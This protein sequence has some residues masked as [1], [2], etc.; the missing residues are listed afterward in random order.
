M[1]MAI[2]WEMIPPN[3]SI[4]DFVLLT[5]LAP[6]FLEA[7]GLPI[8][9]P[10]TGKSLLPMLTSSQQGRIE[11]SRDHVLT[12]V[13]RHT[14]CRPE[15]G[16][17]PSRAIRDYEF[18]YIRNFEPD[19]WPT[20]GPTFVSS[21]KTFHGDVDACP[22]KT[23]MVNQRERFP[24]EYKLCFGKR[25]LE[26][27]YDVRKDLEQTHNLANDERFAVIKLKLWDRLQRK[28]K[29]SGDPRM[30][31]YDPWQKYAYRQ[32]IGFGATFNTSLSEEERRIARERASHNPE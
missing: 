28:L 6:T 11:D 3:R 4:D 7:A 20:G 19:R 15:G 5:D 30:D 10:M 14:W 8:P 9:E 22:T 21:N 17:Y 2:R 18:L 16:T 31:G 13:E 32:T 23:F 29:S 24:R 27:L 1:P 26:E 25:P 12:A